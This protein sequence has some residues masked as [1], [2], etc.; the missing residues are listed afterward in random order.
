MAHWQSHDLY[1]HRTSSFLFSSPDGKVPSTARKV[2]IRRLCDILH[3]SIQRRDLPRARRAF[4]LLARC[5]EIEW[6]TIWK[7]GLLLLTHD[8][9]PE[10]GDALC[11]EEKHIDFLRVMML[12]YPEQRESLVQELVLSLALSGRERDA[13]DELELYLPSIPYQDNPVLHTYAGL[14]CLR[15]A[16][17]NNNL[18]GDTQEQGSDQVMLREARQY[19]ERAR[20]LDPEVVPPAFIHK[21]TTLAPEDDTVGN[22]SDDDMMGVDSKGQGRK[23]I[24]M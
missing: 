7:I 20:A 3:L 13:L 8:P 18:S 1:K 10:G 2:H 15:L 17:W 21:F 19:L 23:R 11:A 16:Q 14:I 6:M 4:A 9:P 5:E 12:Q 22:E 24:R